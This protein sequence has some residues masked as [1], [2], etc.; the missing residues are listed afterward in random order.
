[1]YFDWYLTRNKEDIIAA[2]NSATTTENQMPS[3]PNKI[4]SIKM[5]ETSQTI[6]CKNEIIAEVTPSFKAVKKEDVKIVKPE[7]KKANE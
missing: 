1:M 4:G 7:S 2:I 5:N 3:S 6:E